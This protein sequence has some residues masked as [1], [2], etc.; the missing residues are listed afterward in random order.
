MAKH[1]LTS[2]S[3]TT[4]PSSTA[5]L[6]P[7]FDIFGLAVD[8]FD[9]FVTIERSTTTNPNHSNISSQ[10]RM[11][12][13][14]AS[15][16]VR[17]EMTGQYHESIPLEA[18]KNS[19]GLA[20]QKIIKDFDIKGSFSVMVKKNIPPGFGM[21]SSAAFLRPRLLWHSMLFSTSTFQNPDLVRFAQK[22]KR[23]VQGHCITTM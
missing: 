20:I 11:G 19:A 18:S 22:E 8:A 5:N 4:A 6:G 14:E 1:H 13:D 12:T 21:G 16:P 9:D 10:E 7:G 17:I 3:V 15:F 2:H 23:P